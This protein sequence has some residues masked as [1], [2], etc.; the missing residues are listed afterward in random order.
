MTGK[1]L[2]REFLKNARAGIG[3]LAYAAQ[4]Q[5]NSSSK[6]KGKGSAPV[7]SVASYTPVGDYPIRPMNHAEV[8]IK[9]T[10]WGPKIRTNAEVTI[11]FEI[12]KLSESRAARGFGGG[13]LEAAILSLQTH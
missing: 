12:Q 3:V 11:P 4:A 6:P 9:D 7:I 10:F 5:T 8:R 2:R 1:L 13:V